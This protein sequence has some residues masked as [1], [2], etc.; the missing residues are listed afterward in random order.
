MANTTNPLNYPT[1]HLTLN[2]ELSERLITISLMIGAICFTSY[3]LTR[4]W[5][6]KVPFFG[7]K[8]QWEPFVV[9]SFRF[10][11]YAEDVLLEGYR[12]CKDKVFQFRRADRD[13]LVLPPKFVDEIRKLPNNVASPIVAHAKN[14]LGPTTNMNIILQSNL[15]TRALQLKLTPNINRLVP[16]MQDEAGLA[17][18]HDWEPIKPYYALLDVV[19]RVSAKT[20]LGKPLCRNEDWLEITKNFTENGKSAFGAI[21]ILRLL[22]QWTHWLVSWLIP[23]SYKGAAYLRKAKS[24]LVPEIERRVEMKRQ[25]TA[26]GEDLENTHL[27]WMIDIATEEECDPAFLAHLQVVMALASIH[28]SK[29]NV[30]NV[31]YDLLA[32]PEYLEP[33]REEIQELAKEKPWKTWGRLEFGRLRKLDSFMRESQRVNPPHSPLHAPGGV[34]EDRAF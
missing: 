31:L 13:I 7:T 16:S 32:Y 19:A 18:E 11:F 9:S 22:P 15:H 29:M 25:G 20:F 2:D 14:L 17:I 5:G 10:L 1:F 6:P 8:S 26:M 24:I 12:N 21:I 23:F 30:I 33:L 3:V 34:R 27:S 4:T 28:T